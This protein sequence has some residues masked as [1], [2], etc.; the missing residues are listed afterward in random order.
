MS[1]CLLLNVYVRI[2]LYVYKYHF[3]C[4]SYFF[5]L[6]SILLSLSMNTATFAIPLTGINVYSPPC[7]LYKQISTTIQ[8]GTHKRIAYSRV[9]I[10]KLYCYS[11]DKI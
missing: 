2:D 4:M 8:R 5:M 3:S 9:R 7:V 10:Q 11:L 6:N 1:K